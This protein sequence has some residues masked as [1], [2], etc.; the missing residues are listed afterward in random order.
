[1]NYTVEIPEKVEKQ[2]NRLP[3]QTVKKV[4]SAID[5]L[6][7]NPRPRGC[8]KYRGHQNLWRIWVGRDYR[9]YYEILDQPK[10]VVIVAVTTKQG[11]PF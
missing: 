2:I 10:R 8:R 1:M 5:N 11:S 6:R 4:L 7:Q 3:L 9:V